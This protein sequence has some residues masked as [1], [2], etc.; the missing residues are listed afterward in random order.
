[1]DPCAG[2]DGGG[3]GSLPDERETDGVMEDTLLIVSDSETSVGTMLRT[4]GARGAGANT[5]GGTARTAEGCGGAGAGARPAT[6]E[7]KPIMNKNAYQYEQR[8]MCTNS[9]HT[10]DVDCRVAPAE[11]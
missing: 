7:V 3:A 11:S 1:M 6:D 5:E 4:T 2:V 8:P 9:Y 10:V